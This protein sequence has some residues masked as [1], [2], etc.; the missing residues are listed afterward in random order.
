MGAKSVSIL[1]ISPNMGKV[2]RIKGTTLTN[3]LVRYRLADK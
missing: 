2:T 1:D 3:A